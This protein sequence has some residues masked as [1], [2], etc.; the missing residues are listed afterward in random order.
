LP[1]SKTN[2]DKSGDWRGAASIEAASRLSFDGA[3][4][5]PAATID[6]LMGNAVTAAPSQNA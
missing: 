5:D 2:I 6:V 3:G 1:C 4:V